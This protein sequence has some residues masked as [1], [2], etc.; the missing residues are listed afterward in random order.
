M[1][2]M[3]KQTSLYY[4]WTFTTTHAHIF[5]FIAVV[6]CVIMSITN[7]KINNIVSAPL[8]L[9]RRKKRRKMLMTQNK[10]KTKIILLVLMSFRFLF[11]ALEYIKQG[12]CLHFYCW[13]FGTNVLQYLLWR[14]I[15]WWKYLS[16]GKV[17]R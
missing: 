14:H 16:K 6:F 5:T 17:D 13:L 12:S 15:F 11:T 3:L 7:A 9:F 8:S 2:K 10:K 1:I 4:V